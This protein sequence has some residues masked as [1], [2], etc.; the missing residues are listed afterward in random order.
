[1]IAIRINPLKF[2]YNRIFKITKTKEVLMNLIPNLKILKIEICV[3]LACFLAFV[4]LRIINNLTLQLYDTTGISAVFGIIQLICALVILIVPFHI[5]FA[6]HK[7]SQSTTLFK[8]YI[9]LFVISV[10]YA[11]GCVFLKPMFSLL[12][13][14]DALPIG[15]VMSLVGFIGCVYFAQKLLKEIAFICNENLFVWAFYVYVVAMIF[16]FLLSILPYFVIMT[17]IDI[18]LNAIGVVLILAL[19]SMATLAVLLFIATIRTKAI[20]ISNTARIEVADL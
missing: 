6:L 16:N 17:N 12:A 18:A 8:R 13:G 2:R 20:G 11:L 1:M 14:F 9:L 15:L 19:L 3:S 7:I 5:I 4:I 10:D